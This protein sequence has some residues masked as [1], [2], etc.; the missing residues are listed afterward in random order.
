[1]NKKLSFVL[2]IAVFCLSA[3]RSIT[4][5]GHIVTEKRPVSQFTEVE[6]RSVIPVEIK[7]GADWSVEVEADDN[8]QPFI[9]TELRGDRLVIDIKGK[10]SFRKVNMKVFVTA[11]RFTRISCSGVA[12]ITSNGILKSDER[13]D[14]N[15][16]GVGNITAEVDAPTVVASTS[17]VGG[18]NLQGR[19]RSLD[20]EVSG[21]GNIKAFDLFAEE[22]KADVSGV[23]NIKLFAS[24]SLKANVSG[25]GSILYR[26]AAA[27]TTSVSGVGSVKKA[28]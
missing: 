27:T 4:G 7:N 18:I 19:C 28:D 14:L 24:V 13:L 25:A 3:C 16:S 2:L 21:V 23:G 11:P 1:M 9:I 12:N 10:N 5:S 26:G 6:T 20:A 8:V 17:G 15:T 22:A